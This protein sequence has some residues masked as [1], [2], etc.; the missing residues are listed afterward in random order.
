M[1]S[2]PIINKQNVIKKYGKQLVRYQFISETKKNN[3]YVW[4]T[5]YTDKPKHKLNSDEGPFINLLNF[6]KQFNNNLK[7]AYLDMHVLSAFI[8]I[9]KQM[10]QLKNN[11]YSYH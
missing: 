4:E 5:L 6:L 11:Y 2:T 10:E 8:I 7:Q 9:F 3:R 1:F